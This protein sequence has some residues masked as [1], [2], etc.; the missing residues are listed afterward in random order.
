MLGYDS[1]FAKD[2]ELKYDKESPDE[3]VKDS[4]LIN[5]CYDEKRILIT[6]DIEMSRIMED[7]FTRLLKKN[8]KEALEFGIDSKDGEIITPCILLK[9]RNNSDRLSKIHKKFNLSLK[10]VPRTAR[11]PKC[12]SRLSIIEDITI[13]K[14]KIPEKVYEFHKEFWKC[15]NEDCA[16]IYWK[17]THMEEILKKLK[18][19]KKESVN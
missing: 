17:G 1:K 15:Q 14:D 12:N 18:K 8:P 19:I 13:Y 7:K 16:N 4:D 2:Y 9:E 5:E 6:R 10:Y 11:C 3:S